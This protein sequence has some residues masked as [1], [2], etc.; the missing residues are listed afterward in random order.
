M[1]SSRK[2]LSFFSILLFVGCVHAESVNTIGADGFP[3]L[4]W[5]AVPDSQL[6]AWEIPPQAAVRAQGEVVLSKRNELGQFS[7]LGDSGF[8]LNSATFGS[9]EGLW[10]GMKYP[11][12]A[13]DER[14]KDGVV[15]PYTRA[16]VMAMSGFEAKKAGDIANANMKQLGIKWITYKGKKIIYNGADSEEHY[17]LI[18]R[19]CRAKL[20]QNPKLKQL[21]LSTK[22]LTFMA[23]HKQAVDSLPAY[24][25]HEIYMK[26]RSEIRH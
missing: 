6:P 3:D 12:S 21:L 23:D 7:N 4:W 17:Q 18:L 16:Q 20:E 22:N 26:L 2:I 1:I 24:K 19:A 15:W 11:E 14:L 9:V 13:S 25:Y 10:Q 5:Q 8:K